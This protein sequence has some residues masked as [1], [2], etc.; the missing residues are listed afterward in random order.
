MLEESFKA[1]E[2]Q[3]KAHLAEMRS[4]LKHSGNKGDRVEDVFRK[5]LRKTGLVSMTTVPIS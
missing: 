1:I 3:M 5:F 4:E 2:N